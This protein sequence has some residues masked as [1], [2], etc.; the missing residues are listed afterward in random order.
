MA[1]VLGVGWTL[2]LLSAWRRWRQLASGTPSGQL[3]FDRLGARLRRVWDLAFFQRKLRYYPLAGIAHQL[4]FFG[5]LLLLA[6][7]LQLWGLGFD[8]SFELGV[9]GLVGDVYGCLKDVFVVLVLV[10]TA[11]FFFLRLVRPQHRMTLNAEG[12]AILAVIATMM[13]A[14]VLYDVASLRLA[15]HVARECAVSEAATCVAARRIAAHLSAAP[16]APGWH[17]W[18]MPAAASLLRLT[19]GL[20]PAVLIVVAH[21]GFWTHA[22]LVVV[23]LNWLPHSKHFHV[24]TAIPNVF[25]SSLDAPGRLAPLA[26]SSEALMD[27]VDE[28]SQLDDPSA[29]PVG[30]GRLSHLSRKDRLDL[31][32]C[33]ECGR[34]SARCPAFLTGKKLSPKQLALDLRNH[35]YDP[36]LKGEGADLVPHV[37]DP[38]VLWACTTCRA[39]EEECPVAITFVDKVVQL[40]RPLVMVRGEEFP[41]ELGKPFEAMETNGNPWGFSPL[42]R[43]AWAE[44]L[45][46]PTMA[47]APQTELL[48]W[49]GCAAAY[50]ARA[51]VT[52]RAFV[53]LLHAAQV[54]FAVLGNEE[55]CT[56]DAARRAGNEFLF[57]VLAERNICA[58]DA[59]RRRGGI[60]RIVTICPHCFNTLANEYPDFGG[61]YDVIH[62]TQLLSD[63]L[64]S[65]RLVPGPLPKK[66]VSIHDSCYLGRYNDIYAE[67]REVLRRIEGLELREVPGASGRRGLCCGAGGAQMWMGEQNQD[68][69]NVKR[70]LQLVDT[71][72]PVVA[73]SCPFCATML[74][75]G[76]KALDR[77]EDVETRDVAELLARAC[78]LAE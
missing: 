42:E 31:Y 2:F 4:I 59:Y 47:E 54:Q 33:T 19:T 55:T 3:G 28:A 69:M 32:T 37:I 76:L 18:T 26:A 6:R 52:A 12:T 62:H 27:R 53:R 49:V 8:P 16:S 29:A 9:P 67:P 78:G 57:A 7:T 60:R 36:S 73:S 51:R 45:D 20:S 41:S 64:R 75:D 50:D 77:D 63:L 56:G 34:C 39:C 24:I 1:L 48:F 14:D 30:V 25:F 44:G 15:D 74:T 11:V 17:P 43:L 66:A 70:T 5:F 65:G 46:V 40:R 72:S 10:G 35:L 38:D 61:R 23:F 22:V 13:V 58:I 71:G 68:R 21:V